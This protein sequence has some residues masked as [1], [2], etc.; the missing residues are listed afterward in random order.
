MD[1]NPYAV[2]QSQYPAFSGIMK[3]IADYVLT[4]SDQI[5]SMS[6]QRLASTL[7]WPGR[8]TPQS[9]ASSASASSWASPVLRSSR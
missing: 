9:P 7:S 5:Q 6:V 2:I 4:D 3:K 8:S 1:V